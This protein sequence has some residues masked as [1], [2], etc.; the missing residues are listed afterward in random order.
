M[1][2][3]TGTLA[4]LT[5]A[6][7]ALTGCTNSERA[8][9]QTATT[10]QVLPST[11][12][13]SSASPARTPVGKPCDVSAIKVEG[14]VGRVPTV[15]LPTDCAPPNQ[16]VIKDLVPGTDPTVKAGDTVQVN[17]QLTSWSSGKVVDDSFARGTPFP[18]GPVGQ[19]QVIAGWNEG[20]VGLRTGGRRL[21]IV[22]PDKGYGTRS[23]GPGIAANDTLVFVI[24]GI[25]VQSS[26]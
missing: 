1:R 11:V 5:C 4:L 12:T 15:T 8:S 13:A 26:G 16:L 10:A 19:A 24:D 7:L 14:E 2:T 21:L 9:D 3:T 25:T 17:Y 18:V 22:P 20:L 6:T 23:P